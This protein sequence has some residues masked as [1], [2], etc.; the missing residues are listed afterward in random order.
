MIAEKREKLTIL[1]Q[2]FE[3]VKEKFMTERKKELNTNN[4]Y[5]ELF[6]E[7]L[8]KDQNIDRGNETRIDTAVYIY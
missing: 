5:F 6:L 3:L 7:T 2:N 8:R 4:E 1:K